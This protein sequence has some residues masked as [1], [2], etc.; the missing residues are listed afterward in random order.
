MEGHSL[1]ALAK[2]AIEEFVK[3][4]IRI[5]PPQELT[6]EMKKKAACFVSI[7][8][9]GELRGCIGT[10]SPEKENLANEVISNAI[11][12]ACGDPRFP[13]LSAEELDEITISV[14]VLGPAEPIDS[15]D[16]LDPKRYGVI[17]ESGDKKGALL[18]DLEGVETAEYQVLIARRKAGI[19]PAEKYKLS[20]FEVVRHK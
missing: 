3:Y 5:Q 19:Q 13:R 7:K 11:D 10:T 16:K 4:L 20:R 6:S 2:R 18:P 17:I 12:A 14:D 1:V 15:L 9:G 8:K